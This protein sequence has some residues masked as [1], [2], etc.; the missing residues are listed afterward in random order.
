[1]LS[2]PSDS[3]F[4]DRADIVQYID[5]PPP[6]AIY[7]ILRSCLL[8]LITRSVVSP[9]VCFLFALLEIISPHELVGRPIVGRSTVLKT[10][11]GRDRPQCRITEAKANCGSSLSARREMQGK[12]CM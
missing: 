7:V 10:H 9:A 8:E 5:L 12:P 3:A 11:D 2:F 4:V 1:M 6:E